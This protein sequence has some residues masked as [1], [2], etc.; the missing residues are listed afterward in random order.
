MAAPDSDTPEPLTERTHPMD[1]EFTEIGADYLRT[2][3]ENGRRFHPAYDQTQS[4]A[5]IGEQID[6]LTW[7]RPSGPM[8]TSPALLLREIIPQLGIRAISAVAL[9][10]YLEYPDGPETA[11]CAVLGIEGFDAS[12]RVRLYVLDIGHSAVPLAIDRHVE[13]PALAPLDAE[14]LT[15]TLQAQP[16]ETEPA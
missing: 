7:Q 11:T 8:P 2:A 9:N 1:R 16:Q 15:A 5:L 6:L 14:A 4:R 13:A 12:G 3:H 10:G